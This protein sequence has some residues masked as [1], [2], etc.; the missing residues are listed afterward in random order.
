MEENTITTN[1]ETNN[2]SIPKYKGIFKFQIAKSLL[3]DYGHP[4][5]GMK[6]NRDKSGSVVYF[7]DNSLQL[8]Y[9]MQKIIRERRKHF[10]ELASSKKEEADEEE[11]P[12]QE[13]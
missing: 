4:I 6:L 5:V 7:F 2:E 8:H 9:D 3:E 13:D 1:T 12:Q 11:K 10:A